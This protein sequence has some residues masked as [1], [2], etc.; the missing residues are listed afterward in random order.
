MFE[1]PWLVAWPSPYSNLLFPLSHIFIWCLFWAPKPD[2]QL[3]HSRWTTLHFFLSAWSLLWCSLAS[4]TLAPTVSANQRK[5]KVHS[6]APSGCCLLYQTSLGV[7]W[8]ILWR[9]RTKHHRLWATFCH[10]EL[11]GANSFTNDSTGQ[12][13]EGLAGTRPSFL[14]FYLSPRHTRI[15][16]TS[17]EIKIRP[18][19]G[20]LMQITS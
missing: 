3:H 8:H 16:L 1:C 13:G 6:L 11:K 4:E 7:W 2:P 19:A 17:P 9:L 10:Q 5:V 18:S 20:H 15:C 12:Q 14:H